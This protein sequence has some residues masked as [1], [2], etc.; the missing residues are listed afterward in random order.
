MWI[1]TVRI[2]PWRRRFCPSF[3]SIRQKERRN[4]GRSTVPSVRCPIYFWKN[5]RFGMRG[6]EI[7]WSFIISAPTRW[8]RESICFWAERCRPSIFMRKTK[9][10]N[11]SG[12]DWRPG[13]WIPIHVHGGKN[14]GRIDGTA[15]RVKTGDQ[16]WGGE[17][18][19]WWRTSGI[20]R[21]DHADCRDRGPVRNWGAGR[22]D[23]AWKF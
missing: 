18:A 11:C 15:D 6:K 14:D 2:W 12:K 20:F 13:P 4:C 9:E 3:R 21:C 8:P 17:R 7:I 1:T 23:P 5:C 22:R 10:W 16:F 19:D